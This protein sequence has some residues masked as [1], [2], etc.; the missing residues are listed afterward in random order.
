MDR[1]SLAGTGRTYRQAQARIW[2]DGRFHLQV[3]GKEVNRPYGLSMS[4]AMP[5]DGPDAI[6]GTAVRRESLTGGGKV[7]AEV[8]FVVNP[9]NIL[10]VQIEDGDGNRE[11]GFALDLSLTATQVAD[12]ASV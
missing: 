12:L 6:D 9:G 7:Y 11:Y 3:A 10:H 2:S 8:Q 1:I 4:L 5:S